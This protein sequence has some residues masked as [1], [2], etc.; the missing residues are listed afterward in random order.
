M[1]TKLSVKGLHHGK[2]MLV[3]I[4]VV[5]TAA[6]MIE[7]YQSAPEIIK[8]FQKMANE[9]KLDKKMAKAKQNM[10]PRGA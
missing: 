3:E 4:D 9:V 7:I 5:I 1:Q 10:K 2:P 6:E 8:E